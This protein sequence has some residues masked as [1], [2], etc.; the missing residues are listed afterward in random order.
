MAKE[1]RFCQE[2]LPIGKPL[3]LLLYRRSAV[4]HICASRSRLARFIDLGSKG[5]LGNG[6][7]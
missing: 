1:T 2:Y 4:I 7:E 6:V 3:L 5:Q